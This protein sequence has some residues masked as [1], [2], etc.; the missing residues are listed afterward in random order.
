VR[1]TP[2]LRTLRRRLAPALTLAALAVAVS[3]CALFDGP[4][5]PEPTLPRPP[6]ADIAYGP[7][8]GC[9]EGPDTPC[10]GSQTLD[11]YR[12]DQPGPNPVVIYFHGGGFV[13]G[14]KIDSISANLQELLDG[15]WDIVSANYR[16][17][18]SDGSN[19]FPVAVSDAKR[20]VRWVRANA[21]AQDWDPANVAVMGHSAGGNLAGMVAV[22]AD[23]P[24]FDAPDLP[25]ELA[26]VDDAVVAALAL[27]PVSDLALFAASENLTDWVRQ[28]TGCTGDCTE[29][30]ARGSV[31]THVDDA[32][33]TMLAMHGVND[34]LAAPEQGVLVQEA[35]EAAGIGDRFELVV[36]DDGPEEYQGHRIDYERFAGRF[37][38]FL[39]DQR[40]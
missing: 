18:G 22:T 38:G 32:A 9:P 15:G 6:E 13:T 7:A 37:L 14:D 24:E 40:I 17:T 26:A 2:D 3:G 31:Q 16:L 23:Q 21:D 39:D 5:V 8:T 30:L 11:I 29:A 34:V 27:N 25:D 35:Y 4:S 10:G 1:S 36:V 19:P 33:A 28:Y 12:S 20:A